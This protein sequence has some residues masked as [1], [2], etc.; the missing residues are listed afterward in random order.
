MSNLTRPLTYRVK[1]ATKAST[2]PTDTIVLCTLNAKYIHS[3][4]GLRYL[5]ANLG[6]LK[7]AATLQE[8]TIKQRPIDIV[9]ILLDK[10]PR[11]IGLG[12]YIWNVTETTEVISLIKALAPDIK[13]VIGGPE[14]SYEY[15]NTEIFA[16]CDYLIT[17]QADVAFKE[18]CTHL[19]REKPITRYPPAKVINA[20][21]PSPKSLQLPYRSYTEEDLANR[22]I[23]V[24]ASRGCPF[25]CDFCLSALDRTATPFDLSDFLSEM[26]TLYRRGA[27]Q[28]KFVDRTFN[29]KTANCIAILE[30]FLARLD[31]DLF[32]HFEVIPDRLPEAL[33]SALHKFPEGT[34][35][36]EV[37]IQSLNGDVQAAINRKQNLGKTYNNLTWLRS[38]TG[39]YIHADLIVGLPGETLDSIASGFNELVNL[40]PHEIQVGI[41]KRLRG[42]SIVRHS[43]THQMCY[44]TQAPYQLLCNRDIDFATMQKL[45]RFARYWD[46]IGNSSRFMHTLPVILGDTPFENFWDL[47][48]W[49]F[50]QFRETHKIS[51]KRLFTMI[52]QSATALKLCDETKLNE[53]LTMDFELSG[54]KGRLPWE[55]P[56]NR[57]NK[58]VAASHAT[59][60]KRQAARSAS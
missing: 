28:F 38:H 4:L 53:T 52:H 42:T 17:G 39:A 10:S 37:G 11:I 14:V 18:L 33:K 20:A 29:L 30:F 5:H 57:P 43:K 26:E 54:E 23:Y 16:H 50:L 49:I 45:Q 34:L 24:E 1:D 8:F 15:E 32:I 40:K 36:F 51:Q 3:S 41:L 60:Q 58:S 27:R 46:L 55:C 19:L 44:A 22:I 35:Q 13:V 47:S 12:V 48:N 2:L 9:E 59:R 25:K 31:N 7:S 21:E 6:S 56:A